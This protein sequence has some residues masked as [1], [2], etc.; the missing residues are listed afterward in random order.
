MSKSLRKNYTQP[1]RSD[2]HVNRPL[3]NISVAYLQNRDSFIAGKVF[4]SIPVAKQSDAYFVYDRGD[5][6][7]DEMQERAPGTES[8][9]SAYEI[10]DDTY[11][12]RT[13]ALHRDIPDQ[14]R[15]NADSPISLDREATEFVT[16]KA[17]INREVNWATRYFTPADPGQ[18]W[19]F[20]A[21]GVADAGSISAEF[22]P[23]SVANNKV[24]QWNNAASTPIEDIRGAKRQVLEETG[25][26]PNKLTLGMATYDAL[27]DHPD[28]VGRID[29]GQTAGAAKVNLVTLADLFEVDNVYVMKAVANTSRKGAAA[30]HSFI[31]G[32]HALL[33]YAPATPG[34][35]TPSAGYT[36][37]WTG[38]IGSGEDGI[39]IKRFRQEQL[40]SDRV[41]IEASYDQKRIA[42]D[43]G[44]FFGSIVS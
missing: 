37:N 22:D 43:L 11:Y 30:A 42:P 29:R 12:A 2:V 14:V 5:F 32:S 8:A 10:G 34:I 7:R 21:D 9:G 16:H 13:R 18:I 36:F 40:A 17:M 15:A 6:N 33:S 44:F 31:G 24:L 28:I 35:M 41:E 26:E 25:F 27:L 39:R 19:T 4:P 38:L 3:T 1:S 20:D 23:R